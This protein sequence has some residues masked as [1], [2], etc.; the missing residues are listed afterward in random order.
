MIEVT[1]ISPFQPTKKAY[2]DFSHNAKTIL[3]LAGYLP[4]ETDESLYINMYTREQARL[5]IRK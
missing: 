2:Y 3:L 4:S 1:Y 5:A